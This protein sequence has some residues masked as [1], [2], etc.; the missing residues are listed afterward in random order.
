MAATANT[1]PGAAA[2]NETE[3][4][5]K[6]LIGSIDEIVFEFD[7]EGTFLNIWTTNEQLLYRPA[8]ELVGRKNADIFG[9]EYSRPFMEIFRRV[10]ETGQGENL[11]YPLD[12]LGGKKWFLARVNRI[13]SA[14]GSQHTLCMLVR[15]ITDRKVAE[16]R[17]AKAFQA[18][19]DAMYLCKLTDGRLLEVNDSFLRLTGY[20]REE[21]IGRTTLELGLWPRPKEREQALLLLKRVGELRDLE[22]RFATRNGEPRTVLCS[23]HTIELNGIPC[24][25]TILR[26]VTGRRALEERL[27]QAQKMEAVGRLAGGVAHDF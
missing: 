25:T 3:A 2:Q 8:R 14:D 10:Y 11:E 21:A 26:D 1:Q 5:L 22:M 24:A 20:D 17:F 13:P 12:V 9:A 7:A 6:A 27:R 18:S 23:A 15:D 19:P 4:R 16:E